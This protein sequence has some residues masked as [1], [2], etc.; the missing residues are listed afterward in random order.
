MNTGLSRAEITN[1]MSLSL[2]SGHPAILV[3]D[4]DVFARNLLSR[5]LS[6]DGYVVLGAANCEE[7]I[8]LSHSFIGKIHLFLCNF[9]LPGRESLT[10]RIVRERPEIRVI[11]ISVATH[12]AMIERCPVRG[13]ASSGGAALPEALDHQIRRALGDAELGDAAEV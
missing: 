10:S 2:P 4:S 11:V 7:T 12:A 9:D 1:M 13:G 3:A 8:A 5:E 6:R